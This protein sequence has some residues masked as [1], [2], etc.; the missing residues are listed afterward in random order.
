MVR[1]LIS[2][3]LIGGILTE[4]FWGLNTKE[5]EQK[6][7][8]IKET[9]KVV[10]ADFPKNLK[11]GLVDGVFYVPEGVTRIEARAYEGLDG[12]LIDQENERI[13]KVVLPSSVEYIGDYAFS[14][15]TIEEIVI[16]GNVKEMGADVFFACDNLKKVT[17]EEGIEKIGGG[18]FRE[19]SNLE[20]ITLPREIHEW[21]TTCAFCRCESLKNI[22]LPQKGMTIL[23]TGMFLGC[24]ALE[25]LVIPDCVTTMNYGVVQSCENLKLL[26]AGDSVVNF[27]AGTNHD[28]DMLNFTLGCFGAP[29]WNADLSVNKSSSDMVL[30]APVDSAIVEYARNYP[31]FTVKYAYPEFERIEYS[32]DG[33]LKKINYTANADYQNLYATE[34]ETKIYPRG[35]KIRSGTLTVLEKGIYG[36]DG[37]VELIHEVSPIII[38]MDVTW[39]VPDYRIFRW[40]YYT[41]DEKLEFTVKH[42]DYFIYNKQVKVKWKKVKNADG[43]IVYMKAGKFFKIRAYRKVNGKKVY[44]GYSDVKKIKMK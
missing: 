22:Q 15:S 9:E 2:V 41:Q 8:E 1:K 34:W 11:S 44:G 42:T 17:I 19:C 26:K 10:T 6:S 28:Y 12:F 7:F 36:K 20:S 31:Y 30:E 27:Q 37:Y 16:P 32:C 39:Q 21:D 5:R 18:I 4:A 40:D 35:T 3:M 24:S 13:E 14:Q 23:G 25:E 29:F 38:N 33:I 43:Y